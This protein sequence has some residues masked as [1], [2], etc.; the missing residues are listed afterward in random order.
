[1]FSLTAIKFLKENWKVCLFVL[2]VFA[3]VILWMLWQSQIHKT[4][5]AEEGRDAAIH[6]SNGLSQDVHKYR[7]KLGDTIQVLKSI[8]VPKSQV[9]DILRQKDL[10]WIKKF[11]GIRKNGSN[12]SSAESFTVQLESN[13]IPQTPVTIP[14]PKDSLKLKLY[15]IKD[16][17]ND[18]SVFMADS[19][20]LDIK[21]HYYAIHDFQRKKGWFFKGLWSKSKKFEQ[22][23]QITNSNKKIKMDSVVSIVVK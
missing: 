19:S 16:A 8:M 14:C 10:A 13:E 9:E 11:E 20:R 21:D 4:H 5:D 7:N 15:R 1:M 3:V 17:W 6:V 22:V 18:I 12:L 2:L 23:L